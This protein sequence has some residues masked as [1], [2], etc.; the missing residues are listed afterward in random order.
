MTCIVGYRERNGLV[1]IGADR[2][3]SGSSGYRALEAP[4]IEEYEH[5]CVGFAGDTMM[6]IDVLAGGETWAG[7]GGRIPRGRWRTGIPAL[8]ER[9]QGAGV[10]QDNDGYWPVSAIA[11]SSEGLWVVGADLSMSAIAEGMI[12]IGSGGQFAAGALWALHA[13][14]Q[15]LNLGGDAIVLGALRAAA[16]REERC[17][18][19][20]D[21]WR[22]TPSEVDKHFIG[23]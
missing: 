12:T 10:E 1:W 7:I 18:P 4:K 6:G 23:D 22:I 19:P 2:R 21:I 16:A 20:F 11:A 13:N 14:R 8:I 3:V 9:L 17:G 5:I 15:E